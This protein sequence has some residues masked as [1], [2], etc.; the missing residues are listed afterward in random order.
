MRAIGVVLALGGWLT[1]A[2]VAAYTLVE[3]DFLGWTEHVVGFAGGGST[4]THVADGGAGG[5]GDAYLQITNSTP[6]NGASLVWAGVTSPDLYVAVGGALDFDFSIQVAPNVGVGGDHNAFALLIAQDGS[7]FTHY[8]GVTGVASGWRELARSDTLYAGGFG[9]LSGGGT[10]D[11]TQPFA[12]GFA[13]GNSISG[14]RGSGWD[15]FSLS[16][17]TPVSGVPLPPA[18]ALLGAGPG[19]LALARRRG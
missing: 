5:T 1:A 12:V 19:A 2:P 17:L 10:L 13:S 8:F 18:M 15:D 6:Q 9:L 4:L 7:L 14:V 11:L 3:G 16:G